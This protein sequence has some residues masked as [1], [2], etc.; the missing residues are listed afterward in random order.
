[1]EDFCIL[2][3]AS[4]KVRCDM[5]AAAPPMPGV[6]VPKQVLLVQRE[7]RRAIRRYR[8]RRLRRLNACKNFD[9]LFWG[10]ST[11]V[12]TEDVCRLLLCAR[13]LQKDAMATRIQRAFRRYVSISHPR[14]FY[15]RR[16]LHLKD[17]LKRRRRS[18]KKGS[19]CVRDNPAPK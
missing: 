19:D 5:L 4:W 11:L 3:H 6:A 10:I 17:A 7:W 13:M 1:M 18:G 15:I 2:M 16:S 14:S 9:R 8:E 12:L